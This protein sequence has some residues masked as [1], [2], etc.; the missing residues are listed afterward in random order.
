M[1]DVIEAMNGQDLDEHNIT[2]NEAQSHGGGG[3]GDGGGFCSGGSGNGRGERGGGYGR[4]EA[5]SSGFSGGGYGGSRNHGDSAHGRGSRD[6]GVLCNIKGHLDGSLV[7]Y[8]VEDASETLAEHAKEYLC[9][10][11]IM[12]NKPKS[13]SNS[14][15]RQI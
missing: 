9:S 11:R 8:L 12:G 10:T 7:I 14:D 5:G 1:N 6:R 2:V 15:S 3:T 4:R 13:M